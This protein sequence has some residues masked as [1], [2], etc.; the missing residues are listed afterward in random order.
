MLCQEQCWSSPS[1]LCCPSLL[2]L[3]YSK[4]KQAPGLRACKTQC[5]QWHCARVSLQICTEGGKGALPV[6]WNHCLCCDRGHLALS[7]WHSVRCQCLVPQD[8]WLPVSWLVRSIEAG[9]KGKEWC[10][11]LGHLGAKL[12]LRSTMGTYSIIVWSRGRVAKWNGLSFS[13]SASQLSRAARL[14]LLV[15]RIHRKMVCY[16]WSTWL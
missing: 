16:P 3:E 14:P 1:Y 12:V 4:R 15:P 2:S 8:L 6:A 9:G 5:R 11:H 13:I 7:S 10:G